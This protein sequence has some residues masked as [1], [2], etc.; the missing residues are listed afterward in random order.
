MLK[1][2]IL[3]KPEMEAIR[4]EVDQ[5]LE[6]SIAFAET[7]PSLKPEDALKDVY[8]ELPEGAEI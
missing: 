5:E 2:S 8:A 1:R 3:K 7:S 6:E 4:A